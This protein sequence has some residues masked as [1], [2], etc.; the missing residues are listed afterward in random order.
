MAASVRQSERAL[1]MAQGLDRY[2]L[3][4]GEEGALDPEIAADMVRY[5][6]E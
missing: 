3:S 4:L 2:F 1:E 6:A 5:L